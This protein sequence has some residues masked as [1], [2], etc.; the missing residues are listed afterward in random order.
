MKVTL[1]K[2]AEYELNEEKVTK[3]PFE[4]FNKLTGSDRYE[5]W[6]GYL[7]EMRLFTSIHEFQ[8]VDDS[9]FDTSKGVYILPN[10]QFC[11]FMK[12]DVVNEKTT[13][14]SLNNESTDPEEN[15]KE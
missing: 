12:E 4:M 5:H 3:M 9:S 1:I 6:D 10:G 7:P 2:K 11:M 15:I 8:G 13:D 14:L